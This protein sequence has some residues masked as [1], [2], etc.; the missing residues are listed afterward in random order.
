MEH[1]ERVADLHLHTPASDGT[2]DVETR[3]EQ[4]LE[5]DLETIAV[6]DHDVIGSWFD[7]R[8]VTHR[9]VEVVTG[10]EV[11]ADLFDTKIEMLGYYVNPN[12]ETLR[13]AL[14][15]ARQYRKDRNR[16][17]VERLSDATGLTFEYETLRAEVDGNLG[18]PHLAQ[19]LIDADVVDSVGEAFDQYLG[20][21]GDAY[22]PMDRLPYETVIDAIHAAGGAVSL[23][24][25]GRIRSD[26]VPEM[27]GRLADAGV[28]GIEVWYPYSE[29]GPEAY[30]DIGV[31]EALEL[32]QQHDLVP[33]GGSDCHGSGSDKFRIGTVRSPESTVDEL[34]TTA[35]RN[36]ETQSP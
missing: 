1:G 23:A 7:D 18:R 11:R 34:R 16:A 6:T 24:H 28:D 32:A 4:A 10:V 35:K 5:Y 30:A 29:S 25:P 14:R 21:D 33:T 22:V 9:G 20:S 26:R 15:T 12:E 17:I 36:P 2:D 31:S 19:R 27:V 3:V 8:V 13:D